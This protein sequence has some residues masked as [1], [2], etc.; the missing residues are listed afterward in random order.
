MLTWDNKKTILFQ[1]DSLDECFEAIE[2]IVEKGRE[3]ATKLEE[4]RDG[5]ERER[6][7]AKETI[8]D[9]ERDLANANERITELENA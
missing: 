1:I 7:E 5:F 8:S 6:D 2:V 9:L 4:E 3:F